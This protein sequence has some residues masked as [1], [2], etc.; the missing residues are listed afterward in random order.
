MC[1]CDITVCMIS[2]KVT[3][4]TKYGRLFFFGKRQVLTGSALLIKLYFCRTSY[5][6]RAFYLHQDLFCSKAVPVLLRP[7]TC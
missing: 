4:L 3:V 1:Y 6:A 7:F 5:R 2:A